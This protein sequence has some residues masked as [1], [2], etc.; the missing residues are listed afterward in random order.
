M[1]WENI[2]EIYLDKS[3]DYFLIFRLQ[4]LYHSDF[5]NC[6][7]LFR[8]EITGDSFD[9]AGVFHPFLMVVIYFL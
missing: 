4:S 5:I 3:V 7:S 6:S 8:K 2:P 9:N 1:K